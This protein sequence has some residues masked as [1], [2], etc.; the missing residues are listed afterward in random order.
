MLCYYR[1]YTSIKH[2]EIYR[3]IL[4]NRRLPGLLRLQQVLDPR[5][6]KG[7][8]SQIRSDYFTQACDLISIYR[9]NL[10]QMNTD[11]CENSLL[12]ILCSRTVKGCQDII[13][14]LL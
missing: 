3:L 1:D 12:S 5:N 11:N 10:Y 7:V 4:L 2:F 8:T 14:C 6:D 13:K 9:V